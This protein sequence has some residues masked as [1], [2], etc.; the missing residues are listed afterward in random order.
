MKDNNE[1]VYDPNHL[2]DTL[3]RKMHLKNDAAL[4][5]ALFVA[6]PVIC[7]IRRKHLAVGATILITMHEVSNISIRELRSL[8]GDTASRFKINKL[9]D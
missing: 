3:I 6:P 7:K 5:R 9:N 1:V 8:M 2:L 4:A